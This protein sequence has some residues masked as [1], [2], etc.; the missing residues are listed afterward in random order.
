[1]EINKIYNNDC[2]EILKQLPDKSIDL[3]LTDPPYY[4]IVKDKWDNQWKNITEYQEWCEILAKEFQR[5]LKDNGS[6]YWFGDDKIIAYCQVVFDKYFNLLNNI[7]WHKTNAL[8]H[9]GTNTFRSYAPITERILFYEKFETDKNF[10]NKNEQIKKHIYKPC[11]EYMQAEKERIKKDLN[12]SNVE[13]GELV[14]KFTGT[15]SMAKRHLFEYNQWCFPT[16]K[17]YEN[18]QKGF[19]EYFKKEYEYFKKEYEDLRRIWNIHLLARDVLSFDIC[20]EKGRFHPTQKPIKLIKYLIERSSKENNLILD[21]FSGSGTTAIACSD[22][23]RN[24]ICVEK[25]KK[26]YEESC[27]RLEEHKKQLTLL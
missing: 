18:L 22:L 9:K 5:V 17:H 23:N 13:F 26:Y 2:L 11:I 16:K 14:S 10:N 6:L 25:D 3:I 4:K 19:N 15:S 7:V 24:F 1:M 8:C 21:C 27:K 12:I 20:L